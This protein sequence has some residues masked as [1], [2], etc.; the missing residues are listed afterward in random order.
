MIGVT[1][2]PETSDE[3]RFHELRD[4]LLRACTGHRLD[5]TTSALAAALVTVI[6]GAAKD[7]QQADR[8]LARL[9]EAMREQIRGTV[10]H[11][12]H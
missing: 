11:A 2:G 7:R 6:T 5:D 1:I 4:K 10:G 9:V 8:V 3:C 12:S